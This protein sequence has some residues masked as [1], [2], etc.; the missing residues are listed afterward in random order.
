M[1]GAP[2]YHNVHLEEEFI[3]QNA[4]FTKREQQILRYMIQGKRTEDIANEIHRSIF[5]IQNHR[6]NMAHVIFIAYF[7]FIFKSV[8]LRKSY[9]LYPSNLVS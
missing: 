9:I 8:D 6:K 2:S 7:Q 4:I 3:K 5:T 1:Q